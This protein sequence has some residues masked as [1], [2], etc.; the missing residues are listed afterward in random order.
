VAY[1]YKITRRVEFSETD[2]AGIVH[3]S[4]FCRYMEAV[5][6]AF[7]RSLGFS[8][9]SKDSNNRMG[10]PRV[11]IDV[12]FRTPL[13]FEDLVEIHLLVKEKKRTSLVYTIAF[14][15]ADDPATEIARG[16]LVTAC[17]SRD[18]ATGQMKA[19]AIPPEIAGKIEVAPKE[20]L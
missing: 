12:D 4:N 5:E 14:R 20:S 8:I 11:H 15:R 19:I 3:F 17:V 13:Y 9:H 6:H 10:W 2:L 7:F 16:T 1:E 18:P